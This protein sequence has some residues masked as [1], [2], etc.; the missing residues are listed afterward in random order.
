M[1][2]DLLDTRRTIRFAMR[3][4]YGWHWRDVYYEWHELA[5]GC[6]GLGLL[7]NCYPTRYTNVFNCSHNGS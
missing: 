6:Y 5:N 4:R 3:V 2:L 7:D 1:E